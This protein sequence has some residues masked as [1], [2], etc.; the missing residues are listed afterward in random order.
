MQRRRTAEFPLSPKHHLPQSEKEKRERVRKW[1]NG[2]DVGI[3]A[4]YRL[5]HMIQVL[6]EETEGLICA[7]LHWFNQTAL[8]YHTAFTFHYS[9]LGLKEVLKH[10]RRHFRCS[11]LYFQELDRH[12]YQLKS[13]WLH[14][15]YWVRTKLHFTIIC[16]VWKDLHED[17]S[18][19][20]IFHQHYFLIFE[21][22][23]YLL[24]LYFRR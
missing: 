22:T 10:N 6:W 24:R 15:H 2:K 9:K 19:I 18:N 14:W 12:V 20:P 17:S 16:H 23:C 5:P 4:S 21:H 11:F 3:D 8:I 1:K 13:V 7:L